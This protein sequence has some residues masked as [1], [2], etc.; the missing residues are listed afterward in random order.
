MPVSAGVWSE[1][2]VQIVG[3]ILGTI[4][5]DEDSVLATES[6]KRVTCR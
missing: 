6:R 3:K 2:S 4:K 5:D 1:A